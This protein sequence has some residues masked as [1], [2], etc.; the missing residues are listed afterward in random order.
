MITRKSDHIKIEGRTGRWYVI[1]ETVWKRQRL[2]LLEHETYGD[3]SEAL[4]VTETG[5][6]VCDE[7]YDDWLEHLEDLDDE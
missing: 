6:V 5:K 1:D 4:A 2:Y 7:I 3:E